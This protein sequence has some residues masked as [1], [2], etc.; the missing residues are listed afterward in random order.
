MNFWIFGALLK[1]HAGAEGIYEF[2]LY[3]ARRKLGSADGACLPV[4]AN[5]V[6]LGRQLILRIERAQ[7][8]YLLNFIVGC[9]RTQNRGA[10]S[11]KGDGLE[12]SFTTGE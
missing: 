7:I 11:P 12:L 6:H 9:L 2:R 4:N 3:P 1:G 5:P 10:D 8:I